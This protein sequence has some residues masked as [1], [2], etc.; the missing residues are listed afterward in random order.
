MWIQRAHWDIDSI[1]RVIQKS[2]ARWCCT[3]HNL[4][5]SPTLSAPVNIRTFVQTSKDQD[6]TQFIAFVAFLIVVPL[7]STFLVTILSNINFVL[8]AL[9]RPHHTWNPF[10]TSP[11]TVILVMTT[12]FGNIPLVNFFPARALTGQSQVQL[13]HYNGVIAHTLRYI[14]YYEMFQ[15][16]MRIVLDIVLPVYHRHIQI[17]KLL[18]PAAIMAWLLT[19]AGFSLR[20]WFTRVSLDTAMSPL[21]NGST[22]WVWCNIIVHTDITYQ[23]PAEFEDDVFM[24]C[25]YFTTTFVLSLLF[26]RY[27]LSPRHGMR[28]APSFCT[29]Y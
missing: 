4:I 9:G 5:T 25:T 18:Q 15:L 23:T 12:V 14:K 16:I 11:L 1:I 8:K 19:F 6:A 27:L 10:N 13:G 7:F 22:V 3:N 24:S 17:K 20:M 28:T 2:A 21:Q 26:I 29:L